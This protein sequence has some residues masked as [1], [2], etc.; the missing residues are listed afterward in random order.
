MEEDLEE[1]ILKSSWK[2]KGFLDEI[3]ELLN[4]VRGFP[5]QKRKEL[6]KFT[7]LWKEKDIKSYLERLKEAVEKPRIASSRKLLE[8]M[9]IPSKEIPEE[10]LEDT[11]EIEKITKLF[12]ELRRELGKDLNILIEDGILTRWL[13]EGV[14]EAERKLQSAVDAKAG[15]IRLLNLES[16]GDELKK[17]FL[18]KAFEDFK[19]I[20]KA[21]ELNSQIGYM[22]DYDIIVEYREG[23]L[24]EFLEKCEI[25]YQT[26]KEFEEVYKLSIG[27][28]KEWVGGKSLEEVCASLE[29]KREAVSKEY[30]ELKRRWRELAGILGEEGPEPEGIPDLRKEIGELKRRYKESLGEP[31]LRLLDFFRGEADFPDDL[32]K[33]ELKEALKRL[34]PFIT[35]GFRREA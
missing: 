17:E 4:K 20:E 33:E 28:V 29:E 16:L 22:K 23:E 1:R 3:K 14:S 24:D 31:S 34:R 18:K 8:E 12:N 32:S 10:T 11:E 6:P 25:A 13:K 35:V 2:L 5:P 26:L 27:A 30:N 15:F 7:G 19:S 9:G 21:E